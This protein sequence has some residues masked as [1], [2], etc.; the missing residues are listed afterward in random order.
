MRCARGA[1]TYAWRAWRM[2]VRVAHTIFLPLHVHRLVAPRAIN[3]PTAPHRTTNTN[4]QIPAVACRWYSGFEHHLD[5][6]Q[7]CRQRP[8]EPV[9]ELTVQQAEWQA[10]RDV[11]KTKNKTNTSA[12]PARPSLAIA[13]AS[14]ASAAYCCVCVCVCGMLGGGPVYCIAYDLILPC[15]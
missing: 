10:V 3:P 2:H 5:A 4:L 14:L 9:S 12:R 6:V 7:R 13:I 1:Y 8:A 11:L 15:L